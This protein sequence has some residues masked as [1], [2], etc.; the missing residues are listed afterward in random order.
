MDT[1]N[2]KSKYLELAFADKNT[3]SFLQ[4]M[5]VSDEE[6]YKHSVDVAIFVSMCL[7]EM[8]NANECEYT[9]EECV[10]ITKGALLHD[11]G[12]IFLPFGIQNSTKKLDI[13]MR[14]VM[15]SHP[16]LGYIVIKDSSL[17][18]I[19]KNIVLFHHENADGTGYPSNFET[20][21]CY[22]EEN[23]PAYVWIVS[24]ADRFNAMTE[25][26]N[27]KNSKTYSEAW[28]ELNSLRINGKIPYKYA[29]FYLKV[30]RKLD[31]FNGDLKNENKTTD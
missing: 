16:L 14:E 12:K 27:F 2:K 21:S 13:Y 19:V 31:I 6:T 8:K 11:V 3:E 23:L 18:E 15:K 10:E 4:V 20:G 22:N 1:T 25:Y 7:E 5:K 24:Y 30:I 28:D 17:S 29:S 9:E 26:R